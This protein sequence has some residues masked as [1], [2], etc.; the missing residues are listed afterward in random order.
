M[1]SSAGDSIGIGLRPERHIAG[2]S[3][4]KED[5]TAIPLIF[6][7]CVGKSRDTIVLKLSGPVPPRSS[8]WY[9]YGMQPYCNLTDGSDM[10]V[11]V[12]GPIALDDVASPAPAVAAAPSTAP[13]KVLIITGDN[14][15]DVCRSTSRRPRR[16][17]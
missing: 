6:E 4:R 1:H 16:R 7:A 9:G 17:R 12:F 15:S 10:A 5:G 11:P 3:I 14:V 13:I 8:L 2:F